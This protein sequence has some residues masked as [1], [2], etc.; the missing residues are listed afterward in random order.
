MRV[1]CVVCVRGYG[2]LNEYIDSTCRAERVLQEL[3]AGSRNSRRPPGISMDTSR[4]TPSSDLLVPCCVEATINNSGPEF[5]CLFGC[6][7]TLAYSSLCSFACD[8]LCLSRL[9]FIKSIGVLH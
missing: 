9:P 3:N 4:G 7:C 6:I 2:S 5:R 8:L 1:L